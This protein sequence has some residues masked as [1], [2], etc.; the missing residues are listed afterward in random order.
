ML[1]QERRRVHYVPLGPYILHVRP[2]DTLT[3]VRAGLDRLAGGEALI[4]LRRE[5]ARAMAEIDAGMRDP[6]RS[7]EEVEAIRQALAEKHARETETV[8]RDLTP[9][10]LD[11]AAG[12]ICAMVVAVGDGPG[13]GPGT[14]VTPHR[15]V[16][17]EAIGPNETSVGVLTGDELI[18]V[19]AALSR[20]QVPTM[21]G[22]DGDAT[23]PS[24]PED[25]GDAIDDGAEVESPPLDA[26]AAVSGG[27]GGQPDR[28]GA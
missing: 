20:I 8:A 28:A 18:S 2:A 24:A 22:P 10:L 25:G 9:A 13:P 1:F 14:G 4:E 12:L 21:G 27:D 11:Q 7:P 16:R 5:Q 6:R 15:F 3:L 23:F 17:G 26:G 19:G